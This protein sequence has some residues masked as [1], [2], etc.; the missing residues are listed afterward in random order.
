MTNEFLFI[1]FDLIGTFVFALSGAEA[2]KERELDIFGIAFIAFLTACGG[3]IIRDICIDATPPVGLS[4]WPYLILTLLATLSVII[5]H[6]YILKLNYPTL[7]FDAIGLAMFTV[8]GTQKTLH[9]GFGYGTAIILGTL[10][11]IGGGMIRDTLL[12]RIPVVLRKEI[13]GT[14][15]LLASI[16]VVLIHHYEGDPTVGAWVGLIICFGIRYF[17]L[18]NKWNLPNFKNK[19]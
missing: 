13:Y 14:A 18:K 16:S 7:L 1:T 5:F 11:A 3:G 19:I 10:S 2:S 4:H 6:R 15:A 8:S 9:L 17:S 12:G